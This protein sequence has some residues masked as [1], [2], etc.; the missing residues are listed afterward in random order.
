ME[1]FLRFVSTT[2]LL[3]MILRA[4]EL[5]PVVVKGKTCEFPSSTH[6]DWC[7]TSGPCNVLCQDWEEFDGGECRGFPFGRCICTKEC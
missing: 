1:R 4:T 6:E 2:F 5:G 7:L 3:L